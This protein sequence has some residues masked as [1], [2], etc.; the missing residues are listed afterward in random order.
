MPGSSM[1]FAYDNGYDGQGRPRGLRKVVISWLSDDATGAVTGVTTDLRGELVKAT[2]DPGAAA[3]TANYDI[4]L[5]DEYGVNILAACD[6]DLADRHTSNSEE[7][8]FLVK[9]HAG[10]PLAQSL[11]PVV[12]GP[13]TV[14]VTNAGNAKNGT[15]V[16]FLKD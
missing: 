2:T 1:T 7:M 8:Y 6:D 5:T 16:L 15:L 4:A 9:D 12:A 3:P 13:I 11:P 14:A 10:S